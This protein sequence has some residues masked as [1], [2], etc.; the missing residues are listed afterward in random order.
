MG[1]YIEGGLGGRGILNS[2]N[3]ITHGQE[4]SI[5]SQQ[6]SG[7]HVRNT[8]VY[9]QES[10][11]L[12]WGPG[13]CNFQEYYKH[14]HTYTHTQTHE[15]NAFVLI[16]TVGRSLVYYRSVD[17]IHC[18]CISVV[19]GSFIAGLRRSVDAIPCRYI[20]VG[21]HHSLPVYTGRL[22]SFI[23]GVHRSVGV[24]WGRLSVRVGWRRP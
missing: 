16:I 6:L 1:S 21:W 13:E 12:R 14:I 4:S 15:I 17:V 19:L 23:V 18:R 5:T 8:Q 11:I 22:A 20:P 9:L 3:N 2:K 7:F 24:V 10:Y